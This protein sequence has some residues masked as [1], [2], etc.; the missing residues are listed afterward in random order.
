MYE[1]QRVFILSHR[2]PHQRQK[3]RKKKE[4]TILDFSIPLPV[5]SFF[6]SQRPNLTSFIRDSSPNLTTCAITSETES[7]YYPVHPHSQRSAVSAEK[8]R[9]RERETSGWHLTDWLMPDVRAPSTVNLEDKKLTFS[10]TWWH[11]RLGRMTL[12]HHVC[13][14]STKDF[15]PIRNCLEN[16]KAIRKLRAPLALSLSVCSSCI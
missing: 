5:F 15:Q 10:T 9:G 1:R 8:E 13:H 11:L 4:A 7:K 3:K 6:P 2:Q 16:N 14:Q 12:H